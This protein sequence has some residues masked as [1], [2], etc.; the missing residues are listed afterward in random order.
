M[1]RD[2]AH[3]VAHVELGPI[4]LRRADLRLTVD[5]LEDLEFLR[6]V[7]ARLGDSPEERSLA[8][9]IEAADA[10]ESRTRCA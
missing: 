4:G 8:A 2:R 7:S 3:F 6:H 1:R 5:T 10:C 9:I